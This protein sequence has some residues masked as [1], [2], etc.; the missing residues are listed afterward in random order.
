MPWWDPWREQRTWRR[1]LKD[2]PLTQLR[3]MVERS[4]FYQNPKKQRWA[5]RYLWRQENLWRVDRALIAILIALAGA[6]AG[7]LKLF[8]K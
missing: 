5:K 1:E 3:G 7:Y 6:I 4:L 2:V 8:S